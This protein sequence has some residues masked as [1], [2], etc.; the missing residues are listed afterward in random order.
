MYDD[1]AAQPRAS[2]TTS[3]TDADE[4]NLS[5]VSH[6]LDRFTYREWQ[7]P[8]NSDWFQFDFGADVE[9]QA[10]AVIFPRITNPY[11]QYETQEILATDLIR[12]QVDADG[13]APGTGAVL[14]TNNI[15]CGAW[16]DRGYSVVGLETA[17]TG[18]YWRCSINAAS[19]ATPNFFLV[20][21]AMAGPIFQPAENYVFGDRF[22]FT[23]NSEVQRTP[24]AQIG[25]VTRHEKTLFSSNTWDRIPMSELD[26]WRAMASHAGKTEPVL[27]ALSNDDAPAFTSLTGPNGWVMHGDR[28]MAGLNVDDLTTASRQFDANIRQIQL[29]EHR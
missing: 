23:D 27:F 29:T 24:T 13:G 10:F 2:V 4:V 11:R 25:N 9:L 17:V 16:P 20:S 15:A 8:S 19:R 3:D 1:H 21:M 5:P 18:R 14:D 26:Q 6:V 28:A 22:A 7:A 12:H